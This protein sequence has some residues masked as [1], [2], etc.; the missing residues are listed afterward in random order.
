VIGFQLPK[1]IRTTTV[2]LLTGDA[3]A[4]ATDGVAA[5]FSAVL[6]PAIPAQAQAERMLSE[7]GRGTDDALAVVVRWRG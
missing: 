5:D 4:F 7:H 1:A 3:V 6:N 2:G